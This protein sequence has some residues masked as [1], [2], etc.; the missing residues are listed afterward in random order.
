MQTG[1]IWLSS[2]FHLGHKNMIEGTSSWT[3]K[4]LCR[5]FK[6]VETHDAWIIDDINGKVKQ[7]D[8]LYFLGDFSFG[9]IEKIR[10]Y[11][12][13]IVCKNI[14][15]FIGN[16]DQ[17]IEANREDLQKLF[18][19][20]QYYG[21]LPFSKSEKLILMHYPIASWRSLQKGYPHAYGH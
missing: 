11:R 13:R 3:D 6:T 12:E 20:V 9:G 10:P 7:D 19:S 1:N 21:E 4:S 17:H 8:T 5:P 16:H 15:F 14:H 18:S 2:D